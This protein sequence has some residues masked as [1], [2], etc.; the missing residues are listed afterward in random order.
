MNFRKSEKSDV[1]SIMK[2]IK[3][4]QEYLKSQGIDQW[5]NNYPNDDVINSDISKGESYVVEENGNIVATS[6]ISFNFHSRGLNPSSLDG[7]SF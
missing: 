3:Q 1:K 4:A 7:I 5:Q 6:V 2:I